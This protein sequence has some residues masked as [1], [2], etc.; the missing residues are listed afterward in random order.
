MSCK[1]YK[2]IKPDWAIAVITSSGV[3]SNFFGTST[4]TIAKIIESNRSDIKMITSHYLLGDK[5]DTIFV[6]RIPITDTWNFTGE[7]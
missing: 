3:V 2:P 5:G 7:F 4:W 1:E 6:K